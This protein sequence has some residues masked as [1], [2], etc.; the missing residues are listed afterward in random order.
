VNI[1]ICY[2]DPG[3]ALNARQLFDDFL[4]KHYRKRLVAA[5]QIGTWKG[6]PISYAPKI[7]RL[8]SP[9][10]IVVGEAGRMTHPATGRRHLSGNAFGHVGRAGATQNLETTRRSRTDLLCADLTRSTTVGT[11]KFS[12]QFISHRE[13]H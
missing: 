10:R 8:T 11:D 1:G 6:H 12:T 5:R 13:R 2:E 3:L 9:G 4:S 7:A